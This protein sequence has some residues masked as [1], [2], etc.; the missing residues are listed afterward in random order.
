MPITVMEAVQIEETAT[1]LRF[2][3]IFASGDG[4]AVLLAANSAAFAWRAAVRFAFTAREY[5]WAEGLRAVGRIPL[6]N[7]I[8]IAAGRRALSAYIRTLLG[9]PPRWE[10]TFHDAHPAAMT[11]GVPVA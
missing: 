11:V 10:K 6:S 7:L 9:E 5:G 2:V 1:I 4:L 3:V 8:A